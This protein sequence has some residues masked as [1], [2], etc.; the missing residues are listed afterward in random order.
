MHSATARR[1]WPL[2]SIFVLLAAIQFL[3]PS[4]TG[5]WTNTF[6]EW[7][8]VPV[9]GLIALS[10][11]SWLPSAWPAWQR[12][13]IAFLASLCLAVL[14]EAA[15]IPIQRDASWDDIISDASGAAGFLL[16]ALAY[17]RRQPTAALLS[18]FGLAILIWTAVPLI[19]ATT[20]YVQRNLHFP[21]IFAGDIVSEST[22]V[23]EN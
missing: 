12:A 8:H 13:S 4:T 20:A 18:F 9:F 19:S 10:V 3:R 17:R 23:R 16:L 11:L 2:A 14:S 7:G 22:F 5:L 15:Q 1:H 6:F 21:V